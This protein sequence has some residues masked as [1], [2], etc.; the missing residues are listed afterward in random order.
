MPGNKNSQNKKGRGQR[1]AELKAARKLEEK[2]R[3][4]Q[5]RETRRLALERLRGAG[6][7]VF[8]MPEEWENESVEQML[9]WDTWARTELL[10]KSPGFLIAPEAISETEKRITG[11]RMAC[12]MVKTVR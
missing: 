4:I 5:A 8:M 1:N 6:C 12:S 3:V 9:A 2:Q 11:F 10:S 7:F